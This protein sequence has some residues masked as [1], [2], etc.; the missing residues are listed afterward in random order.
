[1]SLHRFLSLIDP[2]LYILT[3]PFFYCR[4]A[5]KHDCWRKCVGI[6]CLCL[7]FLFEY[8]LTRSLSSGTIL[9]FVIR[10]LSAA[11]F[12]LIQKGL[13]LR[14]A[15]YYSSVYMTV[16]SVV[17]CLFMIE[18]FLGIRNHT[19]LLSSSMLLNEVI[20]H[21]FVTLS[22]YILLLVERHYIVFDHT[23]EPEL[24]QII[25]AS[26]SAICIMYTKELLFLNISNLEGMR[27]YILVCLIVMI[28]SLMILA[29]ID[30]FG[31]KN[32]ENQQ[33][34][35]MKLTDDYRYKASIEN[36]EN[37]EKV[38]ILIHDMKNHIQVIKHLKD[39]PE[40]LTD[41]IKSIENEFSDIQ[42]Q[43][44]TGNAIVDFVLNYKMN[45]AKRHE[46]TILPVVYSE[47][48]DKIVLPTDLCS[49]IS[50]MLDNAIEA[51]D[52][53]MDLEQKR[54]H[55]KMN[56]EMNFWLIRCTN[57]CNKPVVNDQGELMTTKSDKSIHG[58]GLK[59]I[60]RI[61]KKYN[62]T[63]KIILPEGHCFLM[64]IHIP[65][66]SVASNDS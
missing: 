62:G 26:F 53:L 52:Q 12:L 48:I 47:G 13:S 30:M 27:A 36:A 3:V 65:D 40:G 61:V 57:Y 24:Y 18:P 41:Y 51:T 15:A 2:F 25:T 4:L 31:N 43:M 38:R 14:Q 55:F 42:P 17:N 64:S 19:I 7:P 10:Y 5:N 1:M 16:F 23:I 58:L 33:L 45:M 60:N 6:L 59:S 66:N 50:N 63:V 20:S 9:R 56:H 37:E 54:I 22:L 32:R 34:Q 29:V 44:E 39:N 21:L 35:L 8:G 46:I 11:L 28:M 49:L